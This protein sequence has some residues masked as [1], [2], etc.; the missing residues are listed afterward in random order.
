MTQEQTRQLGI[1]FERRLFEIYPQ[2]KDDEK[3]DTDTIYSILSEYQ[4][5][6][7]KG[8]YLADDQVEYS[9]VGQ[10]RIN[11]VLRTLVMHKEIRVDYTNPE[12][13]NNDT[14]KN[15][16]KIL[17]M[18]DDYFLY[19]RSN[20]KIFR[21]HKSDKVLNFPVL[22][23]NKV[24]KE[25][26]VDKVLDSYYNNGA[27]LRNPLI[28]LES[29]GDVPYIKIIHD[30]YTTIFSVEIVYYRQPYAFNVL[31]NNDSDTAAGAIHS[32]CELPFSCFDE[33]LDGALN[34]YIQEYKFKLVSNKN[35]QK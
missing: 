29:N 16:V 6:Y 7:V 2:F 22:T 27:I 5:K 17:N 8:L 34:M 9:S 10:K 20:S 33:L 19:I 14:D 15:N 12:S 4:T 13:F 32:F 21:N 23:P 30:N 11:D 28:V 3:L 26:D 31:K 18:P 24:I 1:E 25:S 35:R